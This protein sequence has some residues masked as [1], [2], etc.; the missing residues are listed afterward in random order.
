MILIPRL[1]T[2]GSQRVMIGLASIAAVLALISSRTG[3]SVRTVGTPGGRGVGQAHIAALIGLA[4]APLLAGLLIWKVPPIPPEPT[5]AET[6]DVLY[7]GEGMNSTVA[8]TQLDG[9]VTSFHVCGKI[10][11]STEPADMR[12]QRMLGHMSA[13]LHPKPRSVLVVGCG[14]GVTAG[15]FLL[16]PEVER[17]VLCEIEPLIPKVVSV[18][19]AQENYGVVDDPRVEIVYDDAR[20]YILTTHEKFDVITSDPIH[21]WVKGSAALYTREYFDLCK[22][23]LNPGG[24]VTQWVPLYESH[25]DVIKSEFATFF[26]AFPEGTVWSNDINGKGYDVI[27]LGQAQPHRIDIDALQQRLDSEDHQRAAESLKEVEFYSATDLLATYAGCGPDLAAWLQDAQINTDR[28]LRLQYLAGMGLNAYEGET[29]YDKI[30]AYRKFPETLFT[31]S[32]AQKLKLRDAI[33]IP[34]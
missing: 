19:F 17:I 8:V 9:A 1:G 14:A 21:P 22:R 15:C 11:A 30:L 18:Y 12:L 31:G 34:R 28:N 7:V 24:L 5:R 23:H 20:H 6:A 29:I 16:H 32:P 3:N 26:T 10:E 4:A 27:L 25:A 33:G 13:L 2:Q